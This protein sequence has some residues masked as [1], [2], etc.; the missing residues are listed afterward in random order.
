MFSYPSSPLLQLPSKSIRA[1]PK[2][3]RRVGKTKTSP[4]LCLTIPMQR[5]PLGT[6]S[7]N[8]RSKGPELSAYVRGKIKAA[9]EFGVQNCDISRA[10]KIPESTIESTLTLDPLR[11]DGKSLP[12]SGRPK[13]YDERD[14][15]HI[16]RHVRLYPKCT[17]ADVRRACAITL[18][19]NT[20]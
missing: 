14:E 6:R 18:C 7:V 10:Y 12:R 16:I 3:S 19:D 5:Q 13:T 1:S 11:C 20:L 17:Y 9:S 8:I 4:L 2:K 15:R